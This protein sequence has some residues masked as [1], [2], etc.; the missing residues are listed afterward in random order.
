MSRQKRHGHEARCRDLLAHAEGRLEQLRS[1]VERRAGERL[2]LERALDHARGLCNRVLARVEAA[3]QASDDSWPFARAHADQA[4]SEMLQAI[5][6]LE[7]QLSRA[8][9]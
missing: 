8:A 9:A 6:E 4:V 1:V 5:D 7:R 3:H 2:D